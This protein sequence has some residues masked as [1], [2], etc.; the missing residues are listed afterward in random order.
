[1]DAPPL[2]PA[3]PDLTGRHVGDYHITRLLGQG[4]M[5][6]VYQATQNSLHREVAFKVL[7][8]ELAAKGEHVAR[9]LDEARSAA[10]AVHPNI[11]QIY[12]MGELD[13]LHFI[14][15]ELVTGANLKQ[16][17]KREGNLP[18][19]MTVNI[20]RQVALAL[21]KAADEQ[22]IHRD[23]KP[24]NVLLSASGEVKVADFGL[25]RAAWDPDSVRKTHPGMVM[26]T[27]LYMSPEQI[28]DG[29]VDHRSDLYSL[30]VTCYHLLAGKPPFEGDTPMSVAIQH[31]QA[32]PTPLPMLRA[33]VPD[34]LWRVINRLMAKTPDRRYQDAVELL[35]D[36]RD[37]AP[38]GDNADDWAVQ[39]L[40]SLTEARTQA[41]QQL[42]KA[43][44]LEQQRRRTGLYS[45]IVLIVG[46]RYTRS[47]AAQRP[48]SSGRR[49]G[50]AHDP[51]AVHARGG[52]RDRRG[53]SRGLDSS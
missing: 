17:L 31:L 10:R 32:T 16:V 20:M 3:G 40:V 48:Q 18:V 47:P 52:G 28:E 27:P 46:L 22:V 43:M 42:Q 36:L 6:T 19:A 35:R 14:A 12:D 30:G 29:E 49:R 7:K 13:G 9:F 34:G 37:L 51:R 45:G 23:I 21:H 50:A 25:A 24:E 33:D 8:P 11:V 41:S 5:A 15:Q 26:G 4:G 1:M 39:E 53:D 2:P 38:N 44:S